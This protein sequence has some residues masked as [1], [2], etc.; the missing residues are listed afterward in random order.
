MSLADHALHAL[1]YA[2]LR[3][4]PPLRAHAVVMRAGRL[5]PQRRSREAVRRAAD[6]LRRGSCLSRALTVAA[7]A[8]GSDVI[9]GV[10]EPGAFEAHAWVELE[11][12]P[13]RP[14]D[15]RGEEIARL[16]RR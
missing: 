10:K 1:A 15:P 11:G 12:Q 3:V 2:A 9:I 14:D 7:R 5:L 4:M 16:R 13:L 6:R 8:P